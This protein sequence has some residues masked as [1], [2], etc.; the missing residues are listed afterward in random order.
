LSKGE[1]GVHLELLTFFQTNPHTRDTV[2]GLARRLH[3]PVEEVAAAVEVLMKA[4][5][6]EKSGSGSSLVYSLR[7]GGLI[8][9]YFEER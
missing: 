4:G 3:R 7:R 5:F 9:T 2:E 6:L 1:Q 8:R